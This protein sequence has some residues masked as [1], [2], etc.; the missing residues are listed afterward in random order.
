M[1]TSP[2]GT[3]KD[4]VVD[5]GSVADRDFTPSLVSLHTPSCL[6]SGLTP[7]VID[8]PT[9]HHRLLSSR[10]SDSSLSPLILIG[11]AF[12]VV[13]RLSLLLGFFLS[14]L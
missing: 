2:V 13:S 11:L 5:T 3:D 10:V 7:I 4:S 8:V 9:L 14:L 1:G 12:C 6:V